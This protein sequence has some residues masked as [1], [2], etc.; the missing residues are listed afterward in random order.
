M[1]RK[2]RARLAA[3]APGLMRLC[4]GPGNG[5]LLGAEICAPAGEHLAHLLALAVDQD[6]SVP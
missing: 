6:L 3:T 5:L 2:G 1:S 4:A